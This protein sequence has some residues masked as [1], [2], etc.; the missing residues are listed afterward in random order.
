MRFAKAAAAA[1]AAA[2]PFCT[3]RDHTCFSSFFRRRPNLVRGRS[4]RVFRF[5]VAPRRPGPS[6]TSCGLALGHPTPR[7]HCPKRRLRDDPSENTMFWP[8][9]IR[10]Q[11]SNRRFWSGTNGETSYGAGRNVF[12]LLLATSPVS[13]PVARLFANAALGGVCGQT[14]LKT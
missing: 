6:K 8:T 5:L 3:K 2:P 11:Q 14:L 9:E 1:Y 13:L 10:N 12:L 7:K 4:R